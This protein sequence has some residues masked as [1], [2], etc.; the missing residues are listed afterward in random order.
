MS[1]DPTKRDP[2]TTTVKLYNTLTKNKEELKTLKQGEVK[3]YVCGPTVYNYIHIGNARVFVFFDVVRRYLHHLGYKVTYVQNFTDVDDRLIN[4]SK[5]TGESVPEIAERYIHAYFDDMDALG[6]KRADVHPRA[7]EHIAEMIEAVQTLIDKGY[8]YERNGDVY[9]RSLRKKD[10]GKLSHQSLD[11]LKAGARIEVN[12]QKEHPLDFALWKAAK[13]GEISWDT[14][15]GPG[16]P[17]WH[18]ECSAMSRKYL[19]DTLDIH[20]G[21]ADLCFPHHENEIAQSEAWTDQPFV[22]YWL[23]NGLINMRNE[24]MSKSLGNVKYV[25]EL[26]KEYSSAAIRY[27]LLSV[28]Y[29]NPLQFS[30]E[31]MNQAEGSVER[32]ETA[33]TNLR[34]RKQAALEGAPAEELIAALQSLSD[35]FYSAMN[36]DFNTANAIS[37]IFEAVKLANEWVA[38]PVISRGSAEALLDWFDTFGGEVLGLVRGNKEESL[39]SE[40]EALIQERQQARKDRNFARADAIRDQLLNRGIILED[41]PQGVRWK[42]K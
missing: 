41:T 30:E 26:R 28:H 2:R 4:A 16:R 36:D 7:T 10:Y 23:H 38:K 11:E 20:A 21:G 24:K 6:V 14:P 3:M 22:R 37:V 9:F 33:V 18:L 31:I 8:A 1:L 34:H 19:G 32:I 5:E 13:P 42:R 39:E 40:I 12:E 15:W 17:G 29:R 35:Q 25:A 27:F